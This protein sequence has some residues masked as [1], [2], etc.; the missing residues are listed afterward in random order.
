MKVS[1]IADEIFRELAEPSTLS[2]A[3]ISFWIKSNIG[4]MNNM[5]NTEYTVNQTTLEFSEELGEEEKSIMKLMYM[6]HYYDLQIR[7]SMSSSLTD[8]VVELES[9]GSRI[10]KLNKNEQSK[11]FFNVRKDAKDDLEK[12]AVKYTLKKSNPLQVAGDD[13]IEGQFSPSRKFNRLK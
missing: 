11:T 4:A 10:K 12:L 13:T 5:I 8:T 9:D 1:Q 2:M 7:S 3:A 6:V